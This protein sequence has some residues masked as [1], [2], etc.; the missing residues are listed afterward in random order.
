MKI[1]RSVYFDP[2]VSSIDAEIKDMILEPGNKSMVQT[3]LRE[4]IRTGHMLHSMLGEVAA[5]NIHDLMLIDEDDRLEML[6]DIIQHQKKL[7]QMIKAKT[8]RKTTVADE[9]PARQEDKESSGKKHGFGSIPE[10]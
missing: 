7:I 5:K 1:H 8:H 10:A 3:M 6:V 9:E 2:S 4:R